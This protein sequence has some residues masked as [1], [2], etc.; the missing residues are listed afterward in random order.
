MD[1]HYV[2]MFT[3]CSITFS[4]RPPSGKRIELSIQTR[5]PTLPKCRQR[6][7]LQINAMMSGNQ[8][9]KLI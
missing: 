1:D 2:D 9:K 4:W 8:D 6:L 3:P 5:P 7:E